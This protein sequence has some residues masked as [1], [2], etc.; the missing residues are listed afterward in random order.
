MPDLPIQER[1]AI[2]P[3]VCELVKNNVNVRETPVILGG[4]DYLCWEWVG[5]GI[6][7][8]GKVSPLRTCIRSSL[9][10]RY[11]RRRP[12]LLEAP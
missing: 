10:D 6:I 8:Q 9:A 5:W 4:E 1:L 2:W 7:G 11:D 3:E 12:H